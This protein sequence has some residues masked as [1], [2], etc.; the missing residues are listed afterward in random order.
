M[1]I[2]IIGAGT[3]AQ[4]YGKVLSALDYDYTVIGRG[5]QSAAKFKEVT[6]KDVVVGG[7]EAFLSTN[8]EPADKAIIATNLNTLSQNTIQLIKYGVKDILCEKPG[9]LYPE[10]CA[11]VLEA[12]KENNA[13]VYLAYNRRFFA[14]V[15]KAQDIIE[16]D[17]GVKSFNFEFTEWGHV[18]EKLDKPKGDLENWMYANSTHVI[19]LAFFLGGNPVQMNCYTAGE[20]SWHKP[21]AFAGAGVTDKGALFN[22]A[23]NW[24]APGRWGVE[25]LTS[26][27]RLY[28][29]PMEQLQIQNIGSVAVTPVEIDD[30]LDKEFKPGFYLETKSFIEGDTISLCSIEKQ[31]E[32]VE[33]IFKKLKGN[34]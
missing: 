3:I 5:E 27:H 23:A 13:G 21:A 8:P 11:T 4:E 1:N 20:L 12:A 10:E 25:I 6:G 24:A 15:L 22:Y 28:L 17:G 9:F 18:I 19:D 26:R 29:R 2:W 7:L 16:E 30:H 34:E 32:H 14:S 31:F 33:N